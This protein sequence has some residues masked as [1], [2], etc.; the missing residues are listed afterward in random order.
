[1]AKAKK[2]K[3]KTC[4]ECDKEFTPYLSTQKVCSTSCAILFASKEANKLAEKERKKK[5]SIDRK[6]LLARKEKL[7]SQSDW[8]KEAQA[9]FNKY[10][11]ARDN[12]KL[13]I[14]CGCRLIG[15]DGYLT[16]SAIDASHY[17]SRGAASHLSFNVYNVHSS[18]TRCNRHLSGNA[19]DYRIRLIKRIGIEKVE[20][21]ESDNK[22]RTFT[23]EYLKRVK[24]I[25]AKRARW[26]EKRRKQFMEAA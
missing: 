2:P 22:P 8:L 18:C 3:L 10:I 21:L 11:R 17:R 16:G 7:K 6:N 4:K 23:I 14:S 25:F 24:R 9:A 12:G 26:Y 5:E 20:A 1:M 13:C 19:V 15:S